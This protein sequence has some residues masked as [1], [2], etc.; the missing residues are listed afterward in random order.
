MSHQTNYIKAI[1]IILLAIVFLAGCNHSGPTQHGEQSTL[2]VSAASSLTDTL[3]EIELEFEEEHPSIN[4]ILNL[5]SSGTLQRQIEQ[6]A[7]ADVFLSASEEKF[8][9]LMKKGLLDTQHTTK[10]LQNELV[11]IT[12]KD[13]TVHLN[14]LQ[15]I[16]RSEIRRISIGVPASVPAGRYAK[17]SLQSTNIWKTVKNKMVYAKDV[18]QVLT[19]VE[20]GNVDIG[21]VYATDA[22]VSDQ[23]KVINTVK[24]RHHSPIIYP[25][26]IVKGTEKQE[27]AIDFFTFLK[28]EFAHKTFKDYGFIPID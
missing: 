9:A 1:Q 27:A 2:Y 23:I 10:L 28:S 17:E 15:G 11:L 20:T 16:T 22:K 18:R 8:E 24:S 6:G 14:E 3:K 25:A 13:H 12:Q 21:F 19:Y 4:V 7:P 26:G 5:A